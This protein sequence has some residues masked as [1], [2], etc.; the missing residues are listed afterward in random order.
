MLYFLSLLMVAFM[1]CSN[2]NFADV[3]KLILNYV[4]LENWF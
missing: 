4:F 1:F 2:T 3:E